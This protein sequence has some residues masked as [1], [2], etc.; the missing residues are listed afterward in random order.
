MRT[1]VE[2]LLQVKDKGKTLEAPPPNHRQ[3]GSVRKLFAKSL[4]KKLTGVQ[5]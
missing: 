4:I 5:P 3:T 1:K 2:T